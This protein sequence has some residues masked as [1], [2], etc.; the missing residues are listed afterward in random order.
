MALASGFRALRH[1]DFRYFWTGQMIS[2]IGSWMQ[3][4]GQS[5]L[6]LELTDSPFRLGLIGTLQFTP[7]LLFSLV[8]GAFID[9][10]RKRRL[11][12][13]TQTTLMLLAFTLSALVLTG[14][15]R[16]WH[17]AALALVLGMVNT[18][19]MPARQ[20]FV[21]DMVGK[22]DLG[23][24]IALNSAIF[25]G[26][27]LLGPA[28]A[29]VLIGRFGVGVAYLLNGISFLP[30]I[31]ALTRIRAEGSPAA[32]PKDSTILQDI[33]EG[34]RYALRTPLTR[35]VLSLLMVISL[36]VINWSVLVPLLARQELH[37]EAQGFGLLMSSLGA[38]A[39]TGALLLATRGRKPALPLLVG[40]GA[41]V[42]LG[43]LA[44]TA[45][46]HFTVAA[47]LLYGIGVS[48]ILFTASCN[49][50]LQVTT[51]DS[52]R[53][54]IMSIYA[55]VFG[56]MTPIGSFF[57]GTVTEALGARAGFAVGGG[58]GLVGLCAMVAWWWVTRDRVPA[59][60]H[61][62]TGTD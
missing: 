59:A 45:V 56:G 14:T 8:A 38:G 57:M 44:M 19:D 32:R 24:A 22:E 49:T 37:Q 23:N 21:V 17:V 41:A 36:F 40:A 15:V 27:R 12:L 30:V 47:A 28:L 52:L 29:G 55:L 6:V 34:V 1:R 7:M 33:L 46:H 42:S 16:Y 10:V 25:N 50:T 35:L 53:G 43:A 4:V 18:L 54:R 39:L 60:A 31:W 51:P 48:Q 26:A 9:R 5:W 3:T 58:L 11:L 13:V 20:S 62:P 2:L 61:T